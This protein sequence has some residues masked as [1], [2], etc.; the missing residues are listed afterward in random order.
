LLAQPLLLLAGPHQRCTTDI[1][2][3]RLLSKV[4]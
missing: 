2:M 4:R 1:L 3:S